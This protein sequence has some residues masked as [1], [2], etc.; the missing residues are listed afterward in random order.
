LVFSSKIIYG[1]LGVGSNFK[2]YQ[3]FY[4]NFNLTFFPFSNTDHFETFGYAY[5]QK[6]I[7]SLGVVWRSPSLDG[8]MSKVRGF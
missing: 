4:G 2:I 3:E 8:V 6:N 5:K 7:M 1:G